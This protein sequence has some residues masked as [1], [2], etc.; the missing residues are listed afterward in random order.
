MLFEHPPK[1]PSPHSRGFTLIELLVVIAIIAILIALLLPAVQQAREAARRSNCK[2]NLHQIGIAIANYHDTHRSLPPNGHFRYAISWWGMILP[3]S[4]QGNL[5]KGLEFGS[6][7]GRVGNAA[8]TSL[9]LDLLANVKPPYMICPSSAVPDTTSHT[10]NGVTRNYV[11]ASYVGIAGSSRG[12]TLRAQ[13]GI[14]S[15]NGCILCNK[16]AI[17]IKDITDGTSN[18]IAVGEQSGWG[19][20][21]AGNQVDYRSPVVGGRHLSAWYG[22]HS[23]DSLAVYTYAMTT[24]RYPINYPT[25]HS[26]A[27]RGTGPSGTNTPIQSAHPGGAQALLMDGSVRF[28]GENLHTQILFNLADRN[29]DNVVSEF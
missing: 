11:V 22:C 29:D 2:N 12:G 5:Y 26:D 4:D 15:A 18:T 25:S 7:S 3:F 13:D 6:N 16:Q 27:S 1:S 17:R 24:V 19:Q 23:E 8:T 28:L 10:L 14:H 21:E 20:N 9:N